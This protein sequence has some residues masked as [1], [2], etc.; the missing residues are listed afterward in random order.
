MA[1]INWLKKR[2]KIEKTGF[3]IFTLLFCFFA[4]WFVVFAYAL[5][6]ITPNRFQVLNNASP[7]IGANWTYAY[8]SKLTKAKV[9]FDGKVISKQVKFLPRGFIF[10]SKKDFNEG[11]HLVVANLYYGLLFP[12]KV[13]LKWRFTTDTIPPEVGFE[14][15]GSTMLATSEPNIILRGSSEP[16]SELKFYLNGKSIFGSQVNENGEFSVSL[17]KLKTKNTLV[18]RAKDKANNVSRVK[19]PIVLDKN[20]PKIN[21]FS[22]APNSVIHGTELNFV[23]K[24]SEKESEIKEV[25]LSLDNENIPIEFNRFENK[26]KKE[27]QILKDGVHK[28]SLTVKDVAGN[29][30]T[31]KWKFSVDTTRVLVDKSATTLY[32]YKRGKVVKTL[33]VAVGQPAYPTPSGHWKVINKV[34]NPAWRN[35][36]SSW[37]SSMPKY[38]PPGPSNPLGVRALYL[39]ASGIR[40]HGTNNIGSIGSPASH[41]CIRVANSQI[42]GLYP[43]INVGTPVQIVD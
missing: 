7:K 16:Y 10:D 2:S 13:T 30:S 6:D 31:K 25:N 14:D 3:I 15:S 28:V 40:I 35:P 36:G 23:L 33:R 22:P 29:V 32:V 34:M 43:M 41:G 38:I 20:S 1:I 27:V 9:I 17:N 21:S 18:V 8:G 26:L 42:I 39:N 11:E 5:I 19:L 37:A 4:V 12:K 24:F